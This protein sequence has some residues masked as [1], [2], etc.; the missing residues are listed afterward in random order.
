[1]VPTEFISVADVLLGTSKVLL[2]IKLP[3]EESVEELM[4]GECIVQMAARCWYIVDPLSS[5]RW[6]ISPGSDGNHDGHLQKHE[7]A[8]VL[9]QVIR[10]M[11]TAVAAS[12]VQ[13]RFHSLLEKPVRVDSV[14]ERIHRFLQVRGFFAVDC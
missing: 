2:H 7:F 11:S 12:S 6:P 14:E 10:D 5:L 3:S 4:R 13:E 9:R 8:S 1:M